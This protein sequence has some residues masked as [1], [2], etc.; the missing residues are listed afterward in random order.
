MPGL[1]RISG[2]ECIKALSHAGW[3]WTATKGSHAKLVKPKFRPLVVPLHP[4]LDRGTLRT[5]IRQSGLSVKE[6]LKLL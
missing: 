1:P 5:I 2:I 3:K 4:E 6:F